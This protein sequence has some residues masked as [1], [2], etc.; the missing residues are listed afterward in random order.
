MS[1]YIYSE[2]LHPLSGLARGWLLL[3]FLGW[4]AVRRIDF[5]AETWSFTFP[6]RGEL[7]FLSIIAGVS[8]LVTV[9]GG[10]SA[11]RNTRF[12][13]A[14]DRLEFEAGWFSRTSRRI[15]YGSVH[16]VSITRPLSAR[17]LGL[18]R[19][20]IQA[21]EGQSVVLEYLTRRRAE[22]L[23]DELLDLRDEKLAEDAPSSGETD[24]PPPLIVDEG[25][26]AA[27]EESPVGA[28]DDPSADR[29]G[30]VL[31]AVPPTRVARARLR[32]FLP[33]NVLVVAALVTVGLLAIGR[34]SWMFGVGV[35]T[36][37]VIGGWV[38]G[39]V[40]AGTA[41]LRLRGSTLTLREGRFNETAHTVALHRV[42]AVEVTRP[43]LWRKLDM[44]IVRISTLGRSN[45]DESQGPWMELRAVTW[46]DVKLMIET[47]WPGED[48]EGLL[49]RGLPARAR[50]LH[51]FAVR[52]LRWGYNRTSFAVRHGRLS[53]TWTLYSLGR[54]QA[55]SLDAGPWARRHDLTSIALWV[56]KTAELVHLPALDRAE[57][58]AAWEDLTSIAAKRPPRS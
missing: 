10:I 43:F 53:P 47:I 50:A 20:R 11:V 37:S 44:Y 23:R 29:D 34:P 46:G 30:A 57:A 55:V 8:L 58:V 22:D 31:V 35:A 18:A 6:D 39:I 16:S 56:P 15:P 32:S 52:S 4:R 33:L 1:G 48:L 26:D 5:D 21:G 42:L 54:L 12:R 24:G 28:D 14:E 2:R 40:K 27:G 36:I 25:T 51:P 19:V 49:T 45:D 7:I 3:L 13:L 9:L 17:I 41:E 38:W